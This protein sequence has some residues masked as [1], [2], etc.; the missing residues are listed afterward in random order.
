MQGRSKQRPLHYGLD[1]CITTWTSVL[2]PGPLHYDLALCI[3]TWP[4]ALRPGPLHYDLA[5]YEMDSCQKTREGLKAGKEGRG[6]QRPYIF[7]IP[8]GTTLIRS[9]KLNVSAELSMRL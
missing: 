1:L 5:L 6:K 2:R 3:T 4:S 9:H 7:V 8:P